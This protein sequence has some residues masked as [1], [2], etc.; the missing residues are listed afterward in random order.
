M[1]PYSSSNVSLFAPFFK[2]ELF[3]VASELKA[4][5]ATLCEV[6]FGFKT[7]VNNIFS[8]HFG[9]SELPETWITLNQF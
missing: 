5:A 3:T 2:A 4:L 1:A 6:D 9:I 8:N 7:D